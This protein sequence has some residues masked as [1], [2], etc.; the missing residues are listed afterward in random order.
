MQAGAETKAPAFH[1]YGTSTVVVF[2]QSIMQPL[3]VF[4]VNFA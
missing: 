4:L 2:M 3:P 1:N